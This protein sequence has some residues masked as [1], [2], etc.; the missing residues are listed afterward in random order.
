MLET[1]IYSREVA[2]NAQLSWTRLDLEVALSTK[3]EQRLLE[4]WAETEEDL[5]HMQKDMND[6]IEHLEM[7]LEDL[8]SKFSSIP[9]RPAS[10][11]AFDGDSTHG[12]S[13]LS[14]AT[15]PQ[16]PKS[17]SPEVCQHH[18]ANLFAQPMVHTITPS[19]LSSVAPSLIPFV[20]QF[21]GSQALGNSAPLTS[22]NLSYLP[23]FGSL[24]HQSPLDRLVATPP[25]RPLGFGGLGGVGDPSRSGGPGGLG[26]FGAPQGPPY[27]L[28]FY[29]AA[30]T[31][32]NPIS[33][34]RWMLWISLMVGPLR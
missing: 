1:R 2:H 8:R 30:V 26:G 25:L 17:R 23:S 6:A 13:V 16:K 24:P 11:L 5:N 27:A 33:K 20:R 34:V 14:L 22:S 29:R 21:G 15:P 12:D 18:G 32:A 31:L 7:Q 4:L 10:E 19:I 9:L 28:G 3:V